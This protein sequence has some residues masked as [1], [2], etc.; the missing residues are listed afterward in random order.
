MKAL[1]AVSR[2][3]SA[4]CRR[5][6]TLIELLVVISIIMVLASML[7]PTFARAR[8]TARQVVCVSNL[9]QCG[10]GLMMYMQE[11]DDR[12]PAQD[13]VALTGFIGSSAP[14]DISGPEEAVWIGQ[15]YPYLKNAEVMRCKSAD[16]AAVD[17]FSG[18]P[19]GL[20]LNASATSYSWPGGGSGQDGRTWYTPRVGVMSEPSSAM[21]MADCSSLIFFQTNA[22]LMDVA[23]A[24]APSGTY[25][26]GSLGVDRHKRHV[27]GSNILFADGHVK[28]YSPERLLSEIGPIP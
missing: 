7:F 26:A 9:R 1:Y 17:R 25:T 24:N 13:L 11:W 18:M 15:I 23:Y 16:D 8:G 12:M 6:F 2:P 22:G 3:R 10:I 4:A 27:S 19:L 5:G 28:S 20:G 21:V 14:R